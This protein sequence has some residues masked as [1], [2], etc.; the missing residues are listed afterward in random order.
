MRSEKAA[1]ELAGAEA[2]A[3]AAE[4]LTPYYHRP[5]FQWFPMLE[6]YP[7]TTLNASKRAKALAAFAQKAAPGNAIREN[8][9][10]LRAVATADH[11]RLGFAAER[12]LLA[13]EHRAD[14]ARAEPADRRLPRAWV[15]LR[16]V[17][18][19]PDGPHVYE[20][21]CEG[22]LIGHTF[23]TVDEGVPLLPQVWQN[24]KQ[25]CR[26]LLLGTFIDASE[27]DRPPTP[28]RAFALRSNVESVLSV[29]HPARPTEYDEAVEVVM[30][31]LGDRPMIRFM[32]TE[33]VDL[34]R[35]H[36]TKEPL[37]A[38]LRNRFARLTGDELSDGRA[39]VMATMLRAPERAKGGNLP[40]SGKRGKAGDRKG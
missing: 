5:D 37:V 20:A 38:D 24:E 36:E 10:H 28:Y 27:A 23:T 25:M 31:H 11:V 6:P 35:G 4:G 13:I 17:L 15:D 2:G 1:A 7:S 8:D 14:E 26:F 32:L 21:L 40:K 39:Q 30:A 33:G 22:R 18:A 29:G 19:G 9:T 16:H 3:L 12:E 34:A